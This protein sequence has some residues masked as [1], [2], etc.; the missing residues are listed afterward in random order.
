MSVVLVRTALIIGG[1][2]SLEILCRLGVVPSFTVIPPS[3]MAQSLWKILASGKFSADIAATLTNVG[4]AIAAGGGGGGAPGGG[5]RGG[6][7][8][9]WGGAVAGASA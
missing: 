5:G 8:V 2:A 6:V 9:R 1:V 7:G 3:A 4:I